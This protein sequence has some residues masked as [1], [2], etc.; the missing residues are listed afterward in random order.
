VGSR[1]KECAGAL[2]HCD[3]MPG[4]PYR[5]WVAWHTCVSPLRAVADDLVQE[6]L[7]RSAPSI[8]YGAHASSNASQFYSM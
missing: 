6:Q 4:M 7:A 1:S 2:L 8:L 3:I 5:V